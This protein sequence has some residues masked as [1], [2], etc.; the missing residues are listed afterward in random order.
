MHPYWQN[1]G[2]NSFNGFN[3]TQFQ[4]FLEPQGPDGANLIGQAY[5]PNPTVM[6]VEF[7]NVTFDVSVDGQSIGQSRINNLFLVPG[8]NTV[9]VRSTTDQATVLNLITTKYKNGILPLDITGNST[10]V[11]G[12]HLSYFENAFSKS[13][14]HL[15]LN[16]GPALQALGLDIGGGG[17]WGDSSGRMD[18]LAKLPMQALTAESRAWKH[19]IQ[20][21]ITV[22]TAPPFPTGQLILLEH[23]DAIYNGC[24]PTSASHYET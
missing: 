11:N 18:M 15:N 9:P 2:L 4:L 5:I 8:N 7:G 21:E 20:S 13:T 17:S 14:Q 10:V 6:S 16:L 1:T 19:S 23:L 12:Q 22:R 3:I 24:K